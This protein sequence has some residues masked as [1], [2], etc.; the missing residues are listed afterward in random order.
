MFMKCSRK[1]F[2][3][4]CLENIGFG[5][6]RNISNINAVAKMMYEDFCRYIGEEIVKTVSEQCAELVVNINKSGDI[7]VEYN[8]ESGCNDEF[9]ED[10]ME[11]FCDR[12]NIIIDEI[13]EDDFE[14]YKLGF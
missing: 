10:Y 4:E 9:V 11:M 14:A 13:I 5:V 12:A 7:S 1:D 8:Y 6:E 3:I 2:V